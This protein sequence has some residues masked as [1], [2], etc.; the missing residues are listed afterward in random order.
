MHYNKIKKINIFDQF[1][2]FFFFFFFT[3]EYK[4]KSLDDL[5]FK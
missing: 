5:C 1:I 2:I 4:I 3:H